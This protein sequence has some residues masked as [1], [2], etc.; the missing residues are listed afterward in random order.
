MI[1]ITELFKKELNTKLT[2]EMQKEER[3]EIGAAGAAQA[4]NDLNNLC[5]QLKKH[6]PLLEWKHGQSQNC[7][8]VFLITVQGISQFCINIQMWGRFNQYGEPCNMGWGTPHTKGYGRKELPEQTYVL[9]DDTYYTC[10]D[11]LFPSVI[12]RLVKKLEHIELG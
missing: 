1:N 11:D 9:F 3:I 4:V 6:I 10:A 5:T 7:K 2:E 8:L 12:S